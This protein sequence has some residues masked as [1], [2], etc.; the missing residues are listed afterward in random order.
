MQLLPEGAR[1][2][3]SHGWSVLQVSRWIPAWE[4]LG[5]V[6]PFP[7]APRRCWLVR[8]LKPGVFRGEMVGVP[9]EE[10]SGP[11]RTADGPKRAVVD[12]L[13]R[14]LWRQGLPIVVQP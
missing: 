8:E 12:A 13:S 5:L 1:D 11:R 3:K 4:V 14:S 2:R 9:E 10:H 6:V 7:D